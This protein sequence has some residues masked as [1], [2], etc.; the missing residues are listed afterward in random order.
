MTNELPDNDPGERLNDD[1]TETLLKVTEDL[2]GVDLSI[3]LLVYATQDLDSQAWRKV[4]G[5]LSEFPRYM[6]SNVKP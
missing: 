4:M 3:D 1:D 6:K 2:R 5:R